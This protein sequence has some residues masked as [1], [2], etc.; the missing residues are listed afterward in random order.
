MLRVQFAGLFSE[1][2]HRTIAP[3]LLALDRNWM[4]SVILSRTA[5]HRPLQSVR[6]VTSDMLVSPW[7]WSAMWTRKRIRFYCYRPHKRHATGRLRIRL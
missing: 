6:L 3:A 7:V 1:R 5:I 4:R 2:Y